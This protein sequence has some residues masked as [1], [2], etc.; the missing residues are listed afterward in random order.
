M[1]EQEN[2]EVIT[3]IYEAFG[4]GDIP[5]ILEQLHDDVQWVVHQEDYVPTSGN[6]SSKAKVPGFFQ[7]INDS[8]EL[9]AFVPREFVAQ[10][11]TVV[12]IG[13]F[14]FKARGTGKSA[15]SKWVFVWKLRD[16]KVLSYEQF[17]DTALAAA[18]R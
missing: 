6:W 16:G 13:D 15:Q 10:G 2:V 5:F 3:R 8:M 1:S 14:D 11:D 17:H 7:A 4:K 18:F 12:S 9:S